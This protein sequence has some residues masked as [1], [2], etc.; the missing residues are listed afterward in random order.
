[1]TDVEQTDKTV[2]VISPA[3]VFPTSAGNRRRILTVC[4]SFLARGYEIDFAYY[5]FEDEVYRLFDAHP[6]TDMSRMVEAFRNVFYIE[7]GRRIKIRTRAKNFYL[8]DWYGEELDRFVDWYFD[9]F[10]GTAGVIANY[11]FISRAFL[12]MP[13]HVV[14]IIDTHDRFY[15]RQSMYAQYRGQPNFFYIDR[16][17]EATG[18]SRADCVLAIQDAEQEYFSSIVDKPVFI[19]PHRIS[20]VQPGSRPGKIRSIGFIGHGNDPNV[21]S[22]SPFAHMWSARTEN[23]G[24]P[25]LRIA[26]EICSIFRGLELPRVEPLGYC[27]SLDDFYGQVDVVVAPLIMGTGLKIKT[28]EALAYGKPVVGTR[29]A[30]EGLQP[31]HPAHRCE[32]IEEVVSTILTRMNNPAELQEL[33]AASERVFE[34]YSARSKTL[35]DAFFCDFEARYEAAQTK[36]GVDR[37]ANA[38]CREE[39]SVA[40]LGDSALAWREVGLE[41]NVLEA[42][43]RLRDSSHGR[44]TLLKGRLLGTE[45][46]IATEDADDAILGNVFSPFRARWFLG[47]EVTDLQ[48][49]TTLATTA[50]CAAPLEELPAPEAIS[51]RGDLAELLDKIPLVDD[52]RDRLFWKLLSG[53][54]DWQAPA[55]ELASTQFSF[56]IATLAPSRLPLDALRS[57]GVLTVRAE[58]DA[59]RHYRV[60]V[61]NARFIENL[62]AIGPCSVRESSGLTLVPVGLTLRSSRPILGRLLEL[63]LLYRGH[64][65]VISSTDSRTGAI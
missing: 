61:D 56:T 28:V 43:R 21:A 34:R 24:G 48:C 17:A 32:S 26:G 16:V 57:L 20:R 35:E 63:R 14:K 25:V 53:R 46:R 19:L 38:S 22:I 4:E 54:A 36:A 37:K 29:I 18:L 41:S 3:P 2:L 7:P 39:V 50:C 9:N 12:R 27:E 64:V 65:G 51:L 58:E 10:S 6:P 1:M 49:A 33:C 47:K 31:S 30:F 42:T 15:D 5:G 40:S 62:P 55:N 23:S 60:E 45:R 52:D 13:Q 59:E 44:E 11:V 8:D